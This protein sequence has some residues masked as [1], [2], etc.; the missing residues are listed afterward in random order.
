M[1][2]DINLFYYPFDAHVCD[3]SIINGKIYPSIPYCIFHSS[4]VHCQP[5][6]LESEQFRYQTVESDDHQSILR[7]IGDDQSPFRVSA[8]SIQFDPDR[9]SSGS[10]K[11]QDL[12]PLT[13]VDDL[14][15]GKHQRTYPSLYLLF[16]YKKYDDLTS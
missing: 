12:M 13:I 11:F 5:V 15:G 8:K 1:C 4:G 10:F 3:M 6:R 16:R 7:W 14:S 2:C 9:S